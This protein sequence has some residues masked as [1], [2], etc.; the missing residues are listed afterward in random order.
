MYL[1]LRWRDWVVLRLSTLLGNA[2]PL[3]QTE[4]WYHHEELNVLPFHSAWLIQACPPLHHTDM[5]LEQSKMNQQHPMSTFLH[6]LVPSPQREGIYRTQYSQVLM[7]LGLQVKRWHFLTYN[8]SLV[9]DWAKQQLRATC[10][11]VFSW[12]AEHHLRRVILLCP[13]HHQIVLISHNGEYD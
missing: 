6:W 10:W 2:G 13:F 1:F 9:G 7:A 8:K 5:L 3:Y 4:V 11:I 12:W